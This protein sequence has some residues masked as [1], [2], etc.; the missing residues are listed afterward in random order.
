M[1]G[2]DWAWAFP[3]A[4]DGVFGQGST[5]P[6]Y[7]LDLSY[8]SQ[9][10]W[11]L[12]TAAELL[13]APNAT[14]FVFHG[15]NARLPGYVDPVSGA[16]LEFGTII[17]QRPTNDTACATPYF[18]TFYRDCDW[19]NGRGLTSADWW[20]PTKTYGGGA[21]K[22]L[23]S[24]DTLVVRSGVVPLPAAAWLMLGGIGAFG[25]LVRRRSGS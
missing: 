7:F 24:T 25:P 1:G 4:P 3:V 20:N 6:Q 16:F 15:A 12:P 5:S 8:Q 22:Q 21:G 11:R 23:S 17:G 14:D 18:A 19:F 9:F 2:L 10:G 13:G